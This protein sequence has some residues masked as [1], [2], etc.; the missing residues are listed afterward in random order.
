MFKAGM[1]LFLIL[2]LVSC[3][4]AMQVGIGGGKIYSIERPCGEIKV[5]GSYFSSIV[6]IKQQFTGSGFIITPQHLSI[7]SE[8]RNITQIEFTDGKGKAVL[9]DQINTKA[10]PQLN[11]HIYTTPNKNEENTE[12]SL[13]ILPSDYIL[14]DGTAIINDTIRIPLR[15]Q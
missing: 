10:F 13:I 12:A 11:I 1:F 14:C 2:I 5:S 4:R 6:T 8:V 15:P 9:K 3:D 7:I